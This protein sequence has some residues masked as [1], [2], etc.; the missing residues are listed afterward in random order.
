MGRELGGGRGV[1]ETDLCEVI[2][3]MPGDGVV[4]VLGYRCCGNY[5]LQ[6]NNMPHGTRNKKA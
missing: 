3:I 2:A 6:R 4:H 5:V 1:R